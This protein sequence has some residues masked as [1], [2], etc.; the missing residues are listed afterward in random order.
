MEQTHTKVRRLLTYFGIAFAITWSMWILVILS[1]RH[2]V[3]VPSSATFP[4]LLIGSFGPFLAASI[5]CAID[6]GPGAVIA[7]FGRAIRYRIGGRYLLAALLL[8]PVIGAAAWFVY[9]HQVGSPFALA[10]PFLHVP[11][12]FLEM[13]LIGGSIGE[14]FGWAYAID[15]LESFW[16]PLP[17]AAVLGAIWGCWHLP[18]FFIP[19]LSQSYLPF[20][21]FL[22][23][24][25]ALRVLYV[26]AYEGSQKSILTTLL[27]HTSVNVTFNLYPIVNYTKPDQRCFIYF[28]VFTALAAGVV[29]IASRSYR[30]ARARLVAQ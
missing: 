10:T 29:A 1:S 20:G 15:A 7:F 13:L 2:V 19:G 8:A 21:I 18:L 30:G 4:I 26:W 3:A 23:F 12:L 28:A 14:E 17:A 6:G 25:I 16:N 24:T 27:F 11:F 9:A 22:I 5:S